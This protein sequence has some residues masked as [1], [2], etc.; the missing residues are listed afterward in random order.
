MAATA[1]YI[2][3]A[4]MAMGAMGSI[5]QASAAKAEG[6][7]R[8]NQANADAYRMDQEAKREKQ[9]GAANAQ[10]AREDSEAQLARAIAI[11][12]G[13]GGDASTGSALLVQSDLAD[14]GELNAQRLLNNSYVSAQGLTEG[15]RMTRVGGANAAAA[16]RTRAGNALLSGGASIAKT[17]SSTDFNWKP[18]VDMNKVWT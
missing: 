6:K 9:I 10:K 12:G 13:S 5:Q 8:Q 3:I 1:T 17:A 2:A 14:E 16:G 18:K 7:A 4:S 15:A 11:R